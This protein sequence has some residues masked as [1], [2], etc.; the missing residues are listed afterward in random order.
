MLARKCTG[1][2]AMADEQFIPHVRDLFDPAKK[3]CNEAK[4]AIALISAI[5]TNNS[6][7]IGETERS[8]LMNAEKK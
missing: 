1:D 3:R 8:G 6:R 2:G 7:I 5:K 4:T